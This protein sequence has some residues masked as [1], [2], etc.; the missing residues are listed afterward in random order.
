M[1]MAWASSSSSSSDVLGRRATIPCPP[2]SS[3]EAACTSCAPHDEAGFLPH[4]TLDPMSKDP[5]RYYLP[6]GR[7]LVPLAFCLPR[8]SSS[9]SSRVVVLVF[10][11]RAPNQ[12]ALKSAEILVGNLG[13]GVEV[14]PGEVNDPYTMQCIHGKKI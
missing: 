12:R 14:N 5:I 8:S 9:S 11:C 10:V 7:A 13:G 3:R 4:R 1:A 2:R 6:L